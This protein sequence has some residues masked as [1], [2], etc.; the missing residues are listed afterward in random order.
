MRYEIISACA[1]T[2]EL[3]VGNSPMRSFVACAAPISATKHGELKH[4]THTER[5]QRDIGCWSYACGICWRGRRESVACNSPI[6]RAGGHRDRERR[7]PCVEDR[8]RQHA[9][10]RSA[11]SEV[12]RRR[13]DGVRPRTARVKLEV[14]SKRLLTVTCENGLCARDVESVVQRSAVHG[15]GVVRAGF[16]ARMS[17]CALTARSEKICRQRTDSNLCGQM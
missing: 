14:G 12:R 16:Y 15:D 6:D 17:G 1:H 4:V 8:T 9:T 2:L 3:N 10:L 5:P 13:V 7:F 11:L